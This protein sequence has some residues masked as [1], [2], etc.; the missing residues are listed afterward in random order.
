MNTFSITTVLCAN[1]SFD[2]YRSPNGHTQTN[3]Q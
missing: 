2:M 1:D 3:T